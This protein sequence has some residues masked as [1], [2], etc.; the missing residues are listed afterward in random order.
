MAT[1][2]QIKVLDNIQGSSFLAS[3][4]AMELFRDHAP[5][6]E[7]GRLELI[8][9]RDSEYVVFTDRRKQLGVRSGTTVELTSHELRVL[10]SDPSRT[11][12][13]DK[14]QGSSFLAIQAA[15]EVF[16]RHNPDLAQYRIEVVRDGDLVVVVFT[17]KDR[18]AGARGG[19]GRPGFEV[20]LDPR[21]RHVVR[22]NFSR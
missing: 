3:R 5:D 17:D 9:E 7:A 2:G 16:Q 18:P 4:A 15:M 1:T 12:V 20:A 11:R 10:A 19:G 8:R 6:V 14:L 13:V 22:S 21:D